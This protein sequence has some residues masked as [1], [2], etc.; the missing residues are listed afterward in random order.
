MQMNSRIHKVV[1]YILYHTYPTFMDDTGFSKQNMLY[2]AK[3][4]KVNNNASSS[5]VIAS[6]NASKGGC[7]F[8]AECKVKNRVLKITADSRVLEFVL[9]SVTVTKLGKGMFKQHT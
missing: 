4:S 9:R 5:F 8:N 1:L 3:K 6:L 7:L 2:S